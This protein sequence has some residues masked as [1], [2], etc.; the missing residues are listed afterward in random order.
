VLAAFI[1]R[2][3]A[4]EEVVRVAERPEPIPRGDQLLIEV[5]AASVNPRDWLL[6]QGRYVFAILAGGLPLVLGSDVAGVVVGLGPK[7]SG[8]EVG[9]EVLAMQTPRGRFGGFAE[10]VVVRAGA[11]AHKP[12]EVSFGSAAGIGVAGLTALQALRD[13]ARLRAGEHVVVVGASGG[14]GSFAVQLAKRTGARVTGVCS[15]R[16]EALARR[17]GCDEVIDY[18]QVDFRDTVRSADVVFDTIGRER[19]ATVRRCLGPGGRYVTTVPNAGNS[20]D[21]GL[22]MTLGRLRRSARR[23]RTIVCR[24]RGSDL[25]LLAELVAGGELEVLI[26]STWPL[27]QTAAALARSRTKRARGKILISMPS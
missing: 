21:Q 25:R 20:L 6:V 3:G 17:L 11:V 15:T 10:R 27:A 13:K 9:D 14:V 8:F 2:Y 1:E 12:S 22:G 7:A 16:N 4:I 24:S 5:H 26:D 19:L 18:T 23:S